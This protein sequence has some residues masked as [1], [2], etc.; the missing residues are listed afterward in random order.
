MITSHDQSS[1]GSSGAFVPFSAAVHG[2]NASLLFLDDQ[3]GSPPE[4]VAFLNRFLI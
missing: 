1:Y 2:L 3:F 4:T